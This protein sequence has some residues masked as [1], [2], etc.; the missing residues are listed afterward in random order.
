M[1]LFLQ[2]MEAS[3]NGI[4]I[5]LGSAKNPEVGKDARISRLTILGVLND[6]EEGIRGYLRIQP[7]PEDKAKATELIERIA[8]TRKKVEEVYGGR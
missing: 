6:S 5:K 7:L 8:S 3:I 2:V 1:G 4:E